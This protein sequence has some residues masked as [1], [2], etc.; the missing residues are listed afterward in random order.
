[1]L[2]RLA[3]SNHGYD[4]GPIV[5]SSYG[6]QH[7]KDLQQQA[8]L[9]Q[10]CARDGKTVDLQSHHDTNSVED[11]STSAWQTSIE[12]PDTSNQQKVC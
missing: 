4:T 5:L 3:C 2:T 6:Q 10:H 11:P 7:P 1:M 12:Q 8:R 9:Q